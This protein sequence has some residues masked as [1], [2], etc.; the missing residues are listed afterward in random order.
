[1]G[2][3]YPTAKRT[4]FASKT[5]AS[6]VDSDHAEASPGR[7]EHGMV[8]REFPAMATTRMVSG[9][10]GWLNDPRAAEQ[11]DEALGWA[12]DNP[13]SDHQSGAI[14]EKLRSKT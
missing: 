7:I 11:L 1:M 6:M 4:R 14:M 5:V 2:D 9:S 12:R 3:E 13:P 8:R 10:E